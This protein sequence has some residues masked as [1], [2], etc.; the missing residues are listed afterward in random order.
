MQ[1]KLQRTFVRDEAY[2]K[3]RGWII[4]G[5]LKAGSKLKDKELAEQLGV[6][7]TP[8]R[9]ALLR[10]EDDGF[11]ESKPNSS[12]NVSPIDLENSYHLYDIVCS[13]E[14]LALTQSFKAF[15]EE[16]IKAMEEANQRLLENIKNKDLESAIMADNDFHS[17]YIR[18]SKNKELEKILS[19]IKQKLNRLM[20]YC[21]EEIEKAYFSYEEHEKII[22]AIR[23]K[24]LSGALSAIEQNWKASFLRMG[25]PKIPF[26]NFNKE[27]SE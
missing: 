11:V 5:T 25:A 12:T 24:D 8:I 2:I 13:L 21:Y 7:R 9:E 14:N 3:L 17:I 19:E 26:S 27:M 1:E 15:T 6:S 4:N 22:V 23:R 10:L 16:D 18:L 20:L